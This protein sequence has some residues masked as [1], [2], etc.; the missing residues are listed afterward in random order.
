MEIAIGC[1]GSSTLSAVSQYERR[2]RDSEADRAVLRRWPPYLYRVRYLRLGS[3]PG[4]FLGRGTEAPSRGA[5]G[6]NTSLFAVH[7]ST[8][9]G[10]EIYLG[11][12]TEAVAFPV[13]QIREPLPIFSDAHETLGFLGIRIFTSLARQSCG[14]RPEI[15]NLRT[16]RHSKY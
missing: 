1:I 2:N 14:P 5:I 10:D 11:G 4:V 7:D 3:E 6:A 8:N 13:V 16:Y 12:S 15:G 9:A